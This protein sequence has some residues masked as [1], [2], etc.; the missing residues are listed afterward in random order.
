M[1]TQRVL[2]VGGGVA[3]HAA[4]HA[5]RRPDPKLEVHHVSGMSPELTVIFWGRG[6][7]ALDRLLGS[8]KPVGKTL[9]E[10][11]DRLSYFTGEM[12]AL[13]DVDA[14]QETRLV[15]QSQIQRAFPATSTDGVVRA[16]RREPRGFSYR[17]NDTGYFAHAVVGADGISSTVRKT[18]FGDEDHVEGGHVV[19]GFVPHPTNATFGT[20]CHVD[21]FFGESAFLGVLPRLDAAGNNVGV[22]WWLFTNAGPYDGFRGALEPGDR[23][24]WLKLLDP[25]IEEFAPPLGTMFHNTTEFR[26]RA[27]RPWLH[28]ALP[29]GAERAALVGDAW[30][31]A[32]PD[33]GLGVTWAL[34]DALR[35]GEC[36]G[37]KGL[38]RGIADYVRTAGATAGESILG[39]VFSQFVARREASWLRRALV[40]AGGPRLAVHGLTALR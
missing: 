10:P 36:V 30:R 40:S 35:L 1:Q 32:T 15:S 27:V 39:R 19:V 26:P 34:E 16:L 23:S 24:L 37:D 33:F 5:L 21:M 17:V 22:S 28:P 11:L 2:V 38:V 29:P 9:G 12:G 31:A 6:Q 8:R 4:A 20:P 13:G 25:V 14:G 18:V 7:R 3:G